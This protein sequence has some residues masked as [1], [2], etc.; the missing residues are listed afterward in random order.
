[1]ANGELLTE[2]V[3]AHFSGE[4]NQFDRIL[5]Q[6]IASESRIGHSQ[7]ARRLRELRDAPQDRPA[8]AVPLVRASRD[9]SEFIQIGYSDFTLDDLI[10]PQTI[11]ASLQRLVIE[12][13]QHEKLAAH[14]L[15]PRRKVLLHGPPGTGKTLT[16]NAIAGELKLPIARV[17]LEVL[18]SRY[19]GET[20]STLTEVFAEA[21]RLRA[22]Y[23]FDEFD[24]LASQRTSA[25]DVG[26]IRRIVGTF[27]QLLDADASDSIFVAAT[28]I[29]GQVDSALFRR[30]DDVIEYEVPTLEERSVLV[31]RTLRGSRLGKNQILE[32]STVADT[33]SLADLAAALNESR[34]ASVL[35]GESQVTEVRAREAILQRVAR[36]I[37][38]MK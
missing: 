36:I 22:V 4:Q 18:F 33:L 8:K 2:L 9:L 31:Q 24:A 16:A 3:R 17:R 19:L 15:K 21:S 26:E 13:R 1:M 14:G 23:L 38:Q 6:V 5:N 20:A 27:L 30:F 29:A 12:Q 32:L 34:K 7:V 37:P 35:S 10:V 25:G 11:R 28:N